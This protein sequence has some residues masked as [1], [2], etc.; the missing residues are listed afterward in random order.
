MEGQM[1]KKLS[2]GGGGGWG[3]TRRGFAL[4]LGLAAAAVGIGRITAADLAIEETCKSGK[5]PKS[6]QRSATTAASTMFL[7][8]SNIPWVVSVFLPV[9][10]DAIYLL[11]TMTET[12]G[13]CDESLL[14][15]STYTILL[16]NTSH[17]SEGSEQAKAA[18]AAWREIPGI[19][20]ELKMYDDSLLKVRF[21]LDS[22]LSNSLR[23]GRLSL[24]YAIRASHAHR[25]LPLQTQVLRPLYV[26]PTKKGVEISVMTTVNKQYNKFNSD[27]GN[28]N[29]TQM[30]RRLR[31]WLDHYRSL[32]VDMFYVAD[33]AADPKVEE[34]LRAVLGPDRFVYVPAADVVYDDRVCEFNL[35]EGGENWVRVHGQFLVEN[36]LLRIASSS[37][38]LSVDPDEFIYMQFPT[39]SFR[40]LIHVNTQR[41]NVY[42]EDTIKGR[43]N[44]DFKPLPDNDEREVAALAFPP[45]QVV[46]SNCTSLIADLSQTP[47]FTEDPLS[48]ELKYQWNWN[49]KVLFRPDL[50]SKLTVHY[51]AT[52]HIENVVPSQEAILAHYSVEAYKMCG[53][54]DL[55]QRSS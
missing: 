40:Q 38:I 42:G 16:F 25:S 3:A 54:K 43:Y 30:I 50:L 2:N 15:N 41:I 35:P 9:C 19:R 21:A 17:A 23:S 26:P 7:R 12:T 47:D 34:T 44:L 14:F 20:Q 51:P 28:M 52:R 18:A 13:I 37:W 22:D 55:Y 8:D 24:A 46:S 5:G 49:R 33:N 27:I 6:C 53:M 32:D 11:G 39:S 31:P 10:D 29:G 48:I 4:V 36:T 1:K 45:Y